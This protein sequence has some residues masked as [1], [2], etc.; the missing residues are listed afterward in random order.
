MISS[1]S[2]K[3][4]L[5]S[6]EFILESISLV[7]S[8]FAQISQPDDYILTLQGKSHFDA[9]LMRLQAIGETLKKIEKHR[10]GLLKDYPGVNWH[11]I[12]RLRDIISHHYE[13]LSQEIIYYTCKTDLPELKAA[14]ENI[15]TRLKEN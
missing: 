6:F 5:A 4:L 10:P 3:T 1:M 9:T 7:Q 14:I 11:E 2:D 15:I 13:Q 8:W 12:I